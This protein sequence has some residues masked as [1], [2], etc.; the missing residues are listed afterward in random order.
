ML[1]AWMVSRQ[2]RYWSLLIINYFI[3]SAPTRGS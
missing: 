1:F 3:V 2:S